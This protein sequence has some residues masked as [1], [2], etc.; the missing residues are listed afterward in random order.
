MTVTD[1][2]EVQMMKK[3]IIE[4]RTQ[5][6]D[7]IEIGTPG[8]GGCVKVYFNASNK[9][10]AKNRIENAIE[11]CKLAEEKRGSNGANI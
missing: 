5:F 2:Y 4:D 1:E 3:Q 10:E 11:L 9:E 8:K 6:P 7:S